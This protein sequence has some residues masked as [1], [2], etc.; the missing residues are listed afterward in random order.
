MT[1]LM[2]RVTYCDKDIAPDC[3]GHSGLS[4]WDDCLS[5]E[6]WQYPDATTGNVDSVGWFVALIIQHKRETT[7]AGITIPAGTYITIRETDNGTIYVTSF[8]TAE[9]AQADFDAWES[10]YG[11]YLSG[12]EAYEARV[13]QHYNACGRGI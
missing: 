5:E 4:K 10:L 6:L 2:H 13:A 12:Q 9:E 3:E 11:D 1:Q 8:P 7:S